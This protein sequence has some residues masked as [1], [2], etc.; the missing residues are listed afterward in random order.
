M[1]LRARSVLPGLPSPLP[2]K[3]R[4]VPGNCLSPAA[5]TTHVILSVRSV[6]PDQG[7]GFPPPVSGAHLHH[8]FCAILRFATVPHSSRSPWRPTVETLH[9]QQCPR[10][11][12]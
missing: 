2:R 12:E 9:L 1:T 6:T 5:R 7:P 3:A 4:S 10:R 8:D 11:E